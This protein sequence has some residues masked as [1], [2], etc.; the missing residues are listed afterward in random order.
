MTC[1]RYDHACRNTDFP[2]VPRRHSSQ[3]NA[4]DNAMAIDGMFTASGDFAVRGGGVSA[5]TLAEEGLLR[6]SEKQI[7]HVRMMLYFEK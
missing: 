7:F 5:E 2:P 1:F 6:H 3:R 4:M